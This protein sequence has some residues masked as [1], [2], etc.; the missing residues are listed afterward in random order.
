[1]LAF[2]AAALAAATPSPAL[3][4]SVPW[5][6]KVTVTVDDKG[7]E[8]SC[9]Y[10]SSLSSAGAEA[11]DEGTA[12][13]VN[14]A[15]SGKSGLYS[16]VTFERR[17]S[18]GR[19]DSRRVQPGDKLIGRNVMFLTIDA[20]GAIASCHVVSTSGDEPPD[21]GCE[22][23]RK[24]QFQAQASAEGGARQAFMTILAYGHTEHLA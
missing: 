17:F 22:D 13:D 11:C 16:T 7:K 3:E 5:W 19:L 14:T 21:Y 4:A 10:E 24:E 1:V 12:E 15:G 9:L 2:F 8:R 6:E 18:P 20:E 23:A